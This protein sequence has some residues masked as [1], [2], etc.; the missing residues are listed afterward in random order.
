MLHRVAACGL[1]TC[2]VVFCGFM[3][4]FGQDAQP[5]NAAKEAIGR[6][7]AAYLKED[8][9]LAKRELE[10][11]LAIRKD[12]A[13]PHL[14]LGMIAW[15]EGKV[16]D[17]IKSVKEAIKYQPDYP[18]AH[19][20]MGK[21][22]F[23]K[24]DW[25]RAGEEVNLAL[26]Q[27]LKSARLKIL[28]GDIALAQAQ[29]EPAVKLFEQALAQP[30]LNSD[31]ANE[32]RI[33]IEAVKN[34]VE[35]R[36]NKGNPDF[37]YPKFVGEIRMPRPVPFREVKVKLAG[38]LDAQGRFTPFFVVESSDERVTEMYLQYA[39]QRRLTPAKKKGA[40]MPI[41]LTQNF[42]TSVDIRVFR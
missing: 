28:L 34:F 40:P 24:R 12:L 9:A 5:D 23:E 19:S 14:L 16:A 39:A 2:L 37:E 1:E 6:A 38:I 26:T 41:W 8:Y 32:I 21:L 13:E 36:A 10:S 25:K 31:I 20:V 33:K 17:A 18:E 22:Y 27:G 29:Y 15:Q 35:I 4:A 7:Q 42:D 3:V 30:S 11:A